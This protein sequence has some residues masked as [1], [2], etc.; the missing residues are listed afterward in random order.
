MPGWAVFYTLCSAG[1]GCDSSGMKF[2]NCSSE[3]QHARLSADSFAGGACTRSRVIEANAGSMVLQIHPK[4]ALKWLLLA[5]AAKLT[6]AC[7]A[8]INP[9]CASAPMQAGHR[10]LRA[11]QSSRWCTRCRGWAKNARPSTRLFGHSYTSSDSD[12]LDEE[13]DHHQREEQEPP[14]SMMQT[15]AVA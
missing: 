13:E 4:H 10:S 14:T 2:C 5:D 9:S 15:Q 11:S 7:R 12:S 6:D 1:T 3:V 8:C